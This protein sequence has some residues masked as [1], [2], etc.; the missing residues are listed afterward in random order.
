[1]RGRNGGTIKGPIGLAL[2]ETVFVHRRLLDDFL[3]SEP[4]HD[5]VGA[6]HYLPTW[7]YTH[8]LQNAERDAINAQVADLA[9]RGS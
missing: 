2:L 7:S 6:G 9:G 3:G 5:D 4:R 1:M 8:F